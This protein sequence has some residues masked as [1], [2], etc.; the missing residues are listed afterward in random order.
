M[1][2]TFFRMNVH[3]DSLS[4]LLCTFVSTDQSAYF[5]MFFGQK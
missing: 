3:D 4:Q 5:V 2:F 1:D